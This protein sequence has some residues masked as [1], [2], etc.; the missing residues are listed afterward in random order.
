MMLDF[1][2]IADIESSQVRFQDGMEIVWELFI[3][4]SFCVSI[5]YF[6]LPNVRSVSVRT[7]QFRNR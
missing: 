7:L 3:R 2:T 6:A 4:N 1:V 5:S